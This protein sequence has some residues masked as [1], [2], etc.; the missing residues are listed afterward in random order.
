MKGRT[1]ALRGS[2]ALWL[3]E[4]RRIYSI[5]PLQPGCPHLQS[6]S[7]VFSIASHC[8]LQYFSVV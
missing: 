3:F 5:L 2:F 4:W 8:A 1:A 7:G 6:M